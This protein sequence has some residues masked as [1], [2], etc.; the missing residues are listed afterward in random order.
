MRIR[1]WLL[2]IVVLASALW[3]I[4]KYQKMQ[5]KQFSVLMGQI[6]TLQESVSNLQKTVNSA[7]LE[8][9]KQ[10]S[11]IDQLKAALVTKSKNGEVTTDQQRLNDL[12]KVLSLP[13][14][15][16]DEKKVV[17]W[18]AKLIARKN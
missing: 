9:E 16:K 10:R 7:Q 2:L 4:N 13:V 6:I 12:V 11:E 1:Y 15:G 8:Q 5:E 17:Y 3:G 18:A 14:K